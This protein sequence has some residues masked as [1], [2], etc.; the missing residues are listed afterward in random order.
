MNQNLELNKENAVDF[1]RL[2]Y[3]GDPVTAV[4]KYVGEKYI[5]HNPLVGNGK[6][7]FIKYF[8]EMARD[9]PDKTID[10]IRAVAEKDLVALHTHQVWP[11][12]I[13]YVTID[14]F[15][16]DPD[17]KIVE[18]WDSIQEI[19]KESNNGNTMY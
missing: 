16:F 4:K 3:M 2:A 9:Y 6:A 7:P 1:Y 17:G 10:F 19:P 8:S 12:R 11:G 14:F 5:Q 13:E 18:H 15:R